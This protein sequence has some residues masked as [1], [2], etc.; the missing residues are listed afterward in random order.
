MGVALALG[1]VAPSAA[2][3][4]PSFVGPRNYGTASLPDSVAIG[5]LNGDRK[6]DL[7]TASEAGTISVLA[8]RGGGRFR[9]RRD[10]AAG[11]DA[12]SIVI[13]DLNGDRKLDL[14]AANH[15]DSSVSVLM[16][17]GDNRFRARR[18]YEGGYTNPSVAIGNLNGDR[19]PD[20]VTA[21][22]DGWTVS[23]LINATGLCAV[24]NVKG[25]TLPGA[26]RAIARA[27]CRE[28]TV[29]R[30]PTRR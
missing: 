13:A 26:K 8:N 18:D 15:D 12:G 20:L 5:D 9:A 11:S 23:V 10:Y 19:K 28:G 29:S 1:V 21:N 30:A 25:K 3:L 7:A 4:T 2:D 17:R 22:S 16:N 6:L 14:A 27:N 24:P